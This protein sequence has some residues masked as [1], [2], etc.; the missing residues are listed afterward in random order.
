MVR[1]GGIDGRVNELDCWSRDPGSIPWIVTVCPL[2]RGKEVNDAFGRS[3]AE[4]GLARHVKE[5]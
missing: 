3:E 5:P 4:S 1:L 2:I